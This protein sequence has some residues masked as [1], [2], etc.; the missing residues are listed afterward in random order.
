MANSKNSWNSQET[1]LL[2]ALSQLPLIHFNTYRCILALFF[3]ADGSRITC[4]LYVRMSVVTKLWSFLIPPLYSLKLIGW[5]KFKQTDN[6][7]F[8]IQNKQHRFENVSN[9]RKICSDSD[10]AIYWIWF[11]TVHVLILGWW[12]AHDPLKKGSTPST[13]SES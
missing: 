10:I 5:V 4:L 2:A 8:T 6:D 12:R 11:W 3:T 1:P 13:Q 7:S 9:I